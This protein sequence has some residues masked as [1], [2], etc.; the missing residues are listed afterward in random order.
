MPKFNRQDAEN[1][2]KKFGFEN[3]ALLAA[4]RLRFYALNF[5]RNRL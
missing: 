1:A 2:K 3:W 5:A 4:W